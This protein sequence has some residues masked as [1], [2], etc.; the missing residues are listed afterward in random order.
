MTLAKETY[1]TTCSYCG[2]GC[3]VVVNKDRYGRISVE[4][5]K[6][7]PANR[8]MLCSKGMNLHHVV[9]DASDRLTQPMMRWGRSHPLQKVS[10]DDAMTRAAAIFKSIIQKY[11]PDSVGFYVSGQCLTEEYYVVNK[12]V[13]GFLGTNNIDTNSR[14]CMSSA[15]VGYKMALGEDSVPVSYDDLEQA[16]CFF[17]TGANP[18]WCHPIL[19]RRLE[20]HKANNPDVKIIVADPRKTESASM[21]DLHL[22]IKPG[23]DIVLYHAIGRY[24]IETGLIDEEFIK[25]HTEGYEEYLKLVF[26]RTL[27][28]SADVCEISFE[29]LIQAAE[30]IGRSQGY[31]S[32]WAMG[33]N[34]S[35]IGVNK[36]LALIN[37]SLITGKIGKPGCGPFSLTGQPNAMGGREVGGMANLLPAHRNLADPTHRQEVADFWGV[38]SVPEKPGLTA[39]EMFDALLSGSMKAVWIICTNPVVS[40]PDARNVDVALKNSRFVV[41]Q[42]ISSRS[43]TL[44]YADLVLPAAGWLEKDGTMTNSDRRI[45]YLEKGIDPPGQALSDVEI[46]CRFAAKMG[47]GKSFN[48]K[49]TEEIFKEHCRL[50]KGTKIDISGLNYDVL[51][52]QR[53]VQ[54]PFPEHASEGTKRLFTDHQFY[55]PSGKAKI[56]P[57][58]DIVNSEKPDSDFPLI[59]ITGRIRDQ[60]HTMTR[61]G[62]V[63]KLNRHISKPF[64]EIHETDALVRGLKNGEVAEVVNSRGTVKVVVKVTNDIKQGVVFLPMHWGKMLGKDSARANNLTSTNKDPLS[65]EP[66]FKFSAVQVRKHIKSEERIVVIGAGAASFRFVQRYRELNQTDSIAVFSKERNFFYNR[67]LLPEYVSGNLPWNGLVKSTQEEVDLM[68]VQLYAGTGIASIDRIKKAVTDVEGNVHPYDKLI[69]ATGSRANMPA[70]VPEK[71]G[72]FTIRQRED[73]EK[74]LRTV[75]AE[76]SAIIVGGGLLGLEMAD[77]LSS[78]GVRITIVQRSSRLMDRQLDVLA[79]ELL[80]EEFQDRKVKVYF[81]DEILSVSG[82]EHVTG[83]TLKSGKTLRCDVVIYAI[84]T[85]PNIELA[86]AAGLKCNRGTV[87]NDYLQTSDENIFAIG[88][89]AEHDGNLYGITAAAEE[90][91]EK[92]AAFLH[93]DDGSFYQGSLSMNILKVHGLNLCSLGLVEYPDTDPDYEVVSIVDKRNRYYKKCIIYKDRLVGSILFGD[94]SEFLEYRELI[95]G[96]IELGDKRNH[97]LRPGSGSAK[98]MLGKLICSCN[99]VG[100]GNIDT[101]IAKGCKTIGEVGNECGAGT[102]CGSC[103]P[104]IKRLLENYY[105]TT[106]QPVA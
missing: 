60:W 6:D 13:K 53:S 59:L 91:A 96:Q 80:F 32:M 33:L 93:G 36:N 43:D 76:S 71:E 73:A 68:D 30:W 62:K 47:Y 87:V 3:G 35:S 106:K 84:G 101:A 65:K 66:D 74:L 63:Q 78:L 49:S 99:N 83:L 1:K 34:Q 45:T 64:L 85:V 37:L 54:W 89:I 2:V 67:V 56:H 42:D 52:E 103:K 10:W 9:S 50:T 24:L 94:K 90:Q 61:T 31:I 92:V 22:Q 8:G 98:P 4:G 104:E 51:K 5:D 44:P 17:I 55:T 40:L 28:E 88:E 69:L 57:V 18:A 7:H 79:S 20:A 27:K 82:Q 25:S 77:A 102:G 15:V 86:R 39:T 48:Y 21:A 81:N 29:D 16:D 72:I 97:L 38:P 75:D 58:P 23:T 12:L 105:E 26:E 70:G 19:F 14:L 46:L 11:G 100:E 41:V 95:E